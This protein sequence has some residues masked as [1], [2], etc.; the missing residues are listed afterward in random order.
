MHADCQ[1]AVGVLLLEF[2]K[3]IG[4]WGIGAHAHYDVALVYFRFFGRRRRPGDCTEW[5]KSTDA[6]VHDIVVL[7]GMSRS[8]GEG[9]VEEEQMKGGSL[10]EFVQLVRWVDD[11]RRSGSSRFFLQLACIHRYDYGETYILQCG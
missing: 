11:S 10:C 2:G 9:L 7:R 5:R 8:R 6:C 1:M 3:I 4:R